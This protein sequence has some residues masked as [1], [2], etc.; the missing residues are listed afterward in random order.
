MK[1]KDLSLLDGLIVLAALAL[2]ALAAMPTLLEWRTRSRVSGAQE[3]LL[4]IRTALEAY[5]A[6][7]NDLPPAGGEALPVARLT[8]PIPYLQEA[9]AN[10]FADR[11]VGRKA[12]PFAFWVEDSGQVDLAEAPKWYVVSPGPDRRMDLARADLRPAAVEARRPDFVDRLYD[13]TNGTLS[14]GDL[15]VSNVDAYD[16][17]NG[18]IHSWGPKQ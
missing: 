8:T 5:H 11:R 13:P 10:P 4:A 1:R 6:D 9:P 16:P 14:R 18:V 3:D 15:F 17:T 12:K 7:W 2:V